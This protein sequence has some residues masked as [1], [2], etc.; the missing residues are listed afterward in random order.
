MDAVERVLEKSPGFMMNRTVQAIRKFWTEAIETEGLR[1]TP[2]EYFV[3][4]MLDA[5]DGLNQTE[6]A[7]SLMRD[8]TTV[9]RLLDGVVKKGLARRDHPKNDRRIVNTWLTPKGR[10]MFAAAST[11]TARVRKRLFGSIDP[12]DMELTLR[13]MARVRENCRDGLGNGTSAK[14]VRPRTATSTRRTA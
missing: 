7:E 12:P 14:A 5:V 10:E 2:E 4:V 3:L 9:T 6:M 8:R 1:L 13:T 11:V